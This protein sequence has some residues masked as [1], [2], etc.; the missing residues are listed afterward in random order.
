MTESKQNNNFIFYVGNKPTSD[1]ILR[2]FNV[3]CLICFDLS[4]VLAVWKKFNLFDFKAII[5]FLASH[6]FIRKYQQISCI[7]LHLESV[8]FKQQNT[9]AQNIAEC[10]EKRAVL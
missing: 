3:V 10:F 4:N 7:C 5:N 2:Y 9:Y 1:T 8:I 6:L